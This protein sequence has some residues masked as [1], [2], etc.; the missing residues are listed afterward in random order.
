MDWRAGPTG[1]RGRQPTF[2]DAAIQ[3]CLTLKVLFRLPL[4]QVI[5]LVESLLQLAGLDWPVPDFS[6]LS[7]RQKNLTVAIPYRGSKG[8]LHLLIPSQRCKHR[9]PGN[10]QYRHQGRGRRGV[11][12]AQ[13][14]AF[15][16]APV[17]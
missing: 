10:G 3:T 1:K 9:L 13:A 4:R 12:H 5:G 11:A 2:S 7:R 6:T 8:P 15:Q 16:A 17:A 14:R